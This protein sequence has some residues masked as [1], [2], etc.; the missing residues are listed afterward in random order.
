[1]GGREKLHL[2]LSRAEAENVAYKNI[3]LRKGKKDLRG[4]SQYDRYTAA[5]KSNI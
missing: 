1:M 3:I 5:Q 4:S 2:I